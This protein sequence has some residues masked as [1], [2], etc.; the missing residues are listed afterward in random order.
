MSGE[1]RKSLK[2]GPLT[3]SDCTTTSLTDLSSSRYQGERELTL[4]GYA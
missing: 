1:G 2:T 4:A 3:V